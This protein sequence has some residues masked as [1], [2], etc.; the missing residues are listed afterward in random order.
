[1]RILGYF[2]AYL[3]AIV[4]AL[5]LFYGLW[6]VTVAPFPFFADSFDK[7]LGLLILVIG[8]VLFYLGGK[9]LAYVRVKY[10]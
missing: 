4:G 8:I 10:H 9:L 6:W 3:L 1:M 7:K 5:T 2:S